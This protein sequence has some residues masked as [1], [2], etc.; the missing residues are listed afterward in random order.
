M[1]VKKSILLETLNIA[2]FGMSPM[3]TK[4][5]ILFSDHKKFKNLDFCRFREFAFI[6]RKGF[7]DNFL[8]TNQDIIILQNAYKR[9]KLYGVFEGIGLNPTPFMDYVKIHLCLMI[10]GNKA[11]YKK[12]R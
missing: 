6:C 1:K 9:V 7:S 3:R 8:N 11:L 12:P 4:D 2:Q 5:V 10:L